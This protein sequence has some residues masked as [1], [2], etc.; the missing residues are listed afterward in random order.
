MGTER[1]E[2][3]YQLSK[4]FALE[5]N[6]LR[7]RLSK[8]SGVNVEMAKA[9]FE[10]ITLAVKKIEDY[11]KNVQSLTSEEKKSL[12]V[13]VINELVDI[14][15]V[16]ESIEAVLFGWLVDFAIHLFNKLSGKAWY[17]DLFGG[18]VV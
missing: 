6:D 8:I 9:V 11:S 12:A 18:K 15:W 10:I 14:P 7:I 17:I 16:P 5:M 3:V 1:E 13:R 4:Q 2:L